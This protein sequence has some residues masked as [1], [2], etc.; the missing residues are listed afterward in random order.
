MSE[1]NILLSNQLCFSIYRLSKSIIQKYRP[2]LD[3]IDLTYPQY[4]SMIVLWEVKRINVKDLGERLCL[5]SGTLTPLIKRLIDKGLV[6]KKR[7]GADERIVYITLTDK[8]EELRQKAVEV[9]KKMLCSI[10]FDYKKENELKKKLDEFYKLLNC[11][12]GDK[13]D[14]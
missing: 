4:L 11:V 6:E 5:D 7:C 14:E 2:F 1:D 9:P 13:K 10:P 12:E 3:E 8:G